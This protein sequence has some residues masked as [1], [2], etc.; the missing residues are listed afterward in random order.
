ME[1]PRPEKVAVV[2]EVRERLEGAQA[3]ILTEY[4]GLSVREM[5]ELRQAL[6]A[7]GGDYKVYKNTLVKLA[8]AGGRHEPLA[9]LLE[10]PTAIAFV[11]GE[12]SAV[13]KALRDYARANPHLIVKGGLHAEGF[14]SA[15]ELGILAD[16]PSR[17]VLLARVAGAIAAP[18]QQFAGLL[19]A[20]PRSL[21]YGLS[22]LLEQ[23][24]GAPAEV[25]PEAEA[26]APAAEATAPDAEAP[27]AEAPA[28]EAETAPE[29]VA[30]TPAPEA[31]A[32]APEAEAPAAEAPAAE[33]PAAEAPAAEAPAPEAPAAEPPAGEA[34]APEIAEAEADTPVEAE[35]APAET[36]AAETGAETN[37]E[38]APAAEP[39]ETPADGDGE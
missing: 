26:S 7:A 25:A 28:A 21:A 17:D 35:T 1:N 24:G 30:D 34:P 19:Q 38:S 4:R 36:A 29:V 32:P 20:L 23:K 3:S 6:T 12:V 22:A 14:L 15:Q 13:A 8:I 37:D 11:S 2:N 31:E 18:L 16:L 10:G 39:A 9:A 5:A 33:A 27:A